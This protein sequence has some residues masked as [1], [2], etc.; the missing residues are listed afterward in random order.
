MGLRLLLSILSSS[1]GVEG[2]NSRASLIF[3]HA[4]RNFLVRNLGRLKCDVLIIGQGHSA[5]QLR[6][7]FR[8]IPVKIDV[9]PV[10]YH[11]GCANRAMELS[12]GYDYVIL[13]EHDSFP[14][15]LAINS[16]YSFLTQ[17]RDIDLL[18]V[19]TVRR[20]WWGFQGCPTPAGV[21]YP[22]RVKQASTGLIVLGR[23][24][25]RDALNRMQNNLGLQCPVPFNSN[26]LSYGR[27]CD[28]TFGSCQ[29]SD[30]YHS[31]IG[32]DGPF[33]VDFFTCLHAANV[34]P[35]KIVDTRGGPL[36]GKMSI[37]P[38]AKLK[39]FGSFDAIEDSVGVTSDVIS[40]RSV[41]A[42]FFHMGGGHA[43][44]AYM[45]SPM[46]GQGNS[47]FSFLSEL[48]G[49][50]ITH[51][52]LVELLVCNSRDTQLKDCFYALRER[53]LK[54]AGVSVNKY[55]ETYRQVVDF[56][57]SALQDYLAVDY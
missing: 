4:W 55:Y 32:L 23:R 6:T 10:T 8:N 28:I 57:R 18:T 9:G 51:Y 3:L 13:C 38:S 44:A 30:F 29:Y 19:D 11:S 26:T 24:V 50:G 27:V 7:I 2:P 49:E 12:S 5:S 43:I 16:L 1:C 53:A 36:N 56:Y 25:Y 17:N 52:C 14:S 48:G 40:K 22:W 35:G 45:Q 46:E 20:S 39:K 42:P 54:T 34:I 47:Q 41:G 37:V 21:E 31:P 33:S 15:V